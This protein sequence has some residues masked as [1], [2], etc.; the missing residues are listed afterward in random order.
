MCIRDRLNA[1]QKALELYQK[2]IELTE[3]VG[4]GDTDSREAKIRQM[5]LWKADLLKWLLKIGKAL[6]ADD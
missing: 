2:I 4:D 5:A 1:K 6:P 3:S